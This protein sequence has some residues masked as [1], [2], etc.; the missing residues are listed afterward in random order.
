MF[1]QLHK[2]VKLFFSF[3]SS[4]FIMSSEHRH[5]V[6]IDCP[7]TRS[8]KIPIHNLQTLHQKL[9]VEGKSKQEAFGLSLKSNSICHKSS[10]RQRTFQRSSATSIARF[11]CPI[12]KL[13]V[14]CELFIQDIMSNKIYIAFYVQFAHIFLVSTLNSACVDLLHYKVRID[15]SFPSLAL[16]LNAPL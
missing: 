16:S 15:I 11:K 10:R 14:R 3:L 2:Q 12:W 4:H 8:I 6:D 7:P 13:C 5:Y 1:V 9:F